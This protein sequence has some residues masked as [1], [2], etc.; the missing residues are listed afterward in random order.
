MVIDGVREIV[1]GYDVDG[2]HFDDYF[3]PGVNDGV[4]PVVVNRSILSRAAV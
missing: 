4:R 3:Y 1:E 2:I